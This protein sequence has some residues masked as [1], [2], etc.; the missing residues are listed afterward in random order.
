MTPR[1]H[2]NDV[3][4]ARVSKV[5][6]LSVNSGRTFSASLEQISDLVRDG[7]RCNSYSIRFTKNSLSSA[8]N[9]FPCVPCTTI[10]GGDGDRE[11]MGGRDKSLCFTGPETNFRDAWLASRT[12]D[13]N[14]GRSPVERREASGLTTIDFDGFT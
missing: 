9:L 6:K 11:G 10:V 2:K 4:P 1:M 12:E 13:P 3:G 7:S 14:A 5:Q 8:V